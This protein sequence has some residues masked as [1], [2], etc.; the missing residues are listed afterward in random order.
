MEESAIVCNHLET[1]LR[2]NPDCMMKLLEKTQSVNKLWSIPGN[3]LGGPTSKEG[4]NKDVVT[5]EITPVPH[6]KKNHDGFSKETERKGVQEKVLN[7]R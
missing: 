2:G 1:F 6:I 4:R 3:E 5:M 7:F